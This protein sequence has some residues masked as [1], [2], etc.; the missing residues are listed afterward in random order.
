[1]SNFY[2]QN[3][4]PMYISFTRI[5]KLFKYSLTT[6]GLFVYDLL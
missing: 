5:K 2:N 3:T 4:N 6:Q 1:M